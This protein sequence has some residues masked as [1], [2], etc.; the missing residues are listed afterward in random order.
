MSEVV[1]SVSLLKAIQVGPVPPQF[2]R[3]DYSPSSTHKMETSSSSP[4]LAM[5]QTTRGPPTDQ[6]SVRDF[7]ILKISMR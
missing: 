6:N 3:Q 7:R 4:Q 1:I 2:N 5:Q